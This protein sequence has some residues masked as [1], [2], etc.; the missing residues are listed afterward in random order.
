MNFI[1]KE[2]EIVFIQIFYLFLLPVFLIYFNILPKGLRIPIFFVISLLLLG[3][4]H[5][6]KWSYKDIGILK[7]WRKD[8]LPYTLFTISGILFLLWLVSLV[9]H[10][11]FLRWYE[12]KKFLL[13]FIPI[14]VL[15]EILFRGI[16]LKMLLSAFKNIPLIIFINASVF[17]LMHVIYINHLFILPLTFIGGIAFAWMYIKYPNLILISISHTIFNFVA[18]ILGFFVI[19]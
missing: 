1:N 16:L 3:I 2:K 14:S 7:N 4:I 15:Q 17:A 12:N 9:P 11:P 6:A 10:S 5:R 13:L 19:R 18:M 8:Y